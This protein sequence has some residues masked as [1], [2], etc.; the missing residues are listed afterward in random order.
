VESLKAVREE[1]QALLDTQDLVAILRAIFGER[2]RDEGY[3][4]ILDTLSQ[5]QV[6][7]AGSA[8]TWSDRTI[9]PSNLVAPAIAYAPGFHGIPP[10][11]FIDTIRLVLMQVENATIPMPHEPKAIELIGWLDLAMDDAEVVIV[12]GMNDGSV[13]AFQTSDMFLPD[14]LRRKLSIEDNSRRF[15]RDAYAMTCLLATRQYDPQRVQF[16]G[17][18]RS[19]EGDPM[20]PSR[21]FFAADDETVTKRVRD[22]FAEHHVASPRIS[23]ARQ[24][25]TPLVV[26]D[27]P[28][29]PEHAGE[30]IK[31]MR[32]TEFAEYKKC[33]YRYYLQY[34]F[35][36]RALNDE[37]TELHAGTF[38]SLI[39]D[40]LESFGKTKELKDSTSAETIRKFLEQALRKKV[41]Q[42]YGEQPRSVVAIQAE[43]A[44]KRLEAFAHWQANWALEY[45]ILDT[46]LQFG[47]GHFSLDVDGKTM[48]LR[49][50]IDRIDRHRKTNELVIWDYKTGKP[51]D[52]D[53]KHRSKGEWIDFQLPLY[54]HLLS[55]HAEYSGFLQKGFRLGY[56]LLPP[57]A[58]ETGK[59]FA[60]W[61]RDMVLSAIDEARQIV[62]C[63]WNNEF[64][65]TVPPPKYSEAFAAICGDF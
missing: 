6:M 60:V 32:V 13:P 27:L 28:K 3:Y 18:R 52:P 36:L 51:E 40:A 5:I 35:K 29:I 53:K 12:T 20:S 8:T 54:H 19:V 50:R 7:E 25:D 15:A 31:V 34:H 24:E 49:G 42:Q 26:F 37:D 39:H 62:R 65:K 23:F 33:P 14:G 44:I 41:R 21:L 63:I 9:P 48:G 59:K 55:Q 46:E 2:N 4:Q 61:D 58:T 38:G 43:R 22:F 57:K 1:L 45:E 10:F 47:E 17:S 64:E 30:K 11:S 16:I 56:I